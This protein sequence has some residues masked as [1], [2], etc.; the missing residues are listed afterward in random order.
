MRCFTKKLIWARL[1][2]SWTIYINVDTPNLGF[3]NFTFLGG[4]QLKKMPCI[5][6]VKQNDA[7]TIRW[8]K[9]NTGDIIPKI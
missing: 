9:Y 1:G 7:N 2:V 5:H 4:Y 6:I 3:T 8:Q